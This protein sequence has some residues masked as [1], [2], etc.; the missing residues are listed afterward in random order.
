MQGRSEAHLFQRAC[1]C[2]GLSDG[3]TH[4]IVCEGT[5]YDPSSARTAALRGAAELS[6]VE[7]AKQGAFRAVPVYGLLTEVVPT[8]LQVER[9]S[10]RAESDC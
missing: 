6:Q 4:S 8:S 10:A 2:C 9:G 5:S 3:L 7:R 1:L